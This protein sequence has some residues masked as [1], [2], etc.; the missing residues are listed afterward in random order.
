M[1]GTVAE[2][3]S[4]FGA[5]SDDIGKNI[6]FLWST[7]DSQRGPKKADWQELRQYLF[8]TD[9]STTSNASLPWKNT[10]TIPKLCQ[11][12]DNLHSNY[13]S[14]LFPN[15]NWLKWEGAAEDDDS[16]DKQKA[17]TGYMSNKV[18]ESN[19][20][21]TVSE[22]VYDY[23]DYGNAFYD[24]TYENNNFIN[25]DGEFIQGYTG[26]VIQRVSP[27]DIVFNPI[28]P[29]FAKSPKI[30]RRLFTRG[31]VRKLAENNTDWA[32][33][34]DKSDE[35][36]RTVSGMHHLADVDK[37]IG[38]QMDGFGGMKDYYG[39]EVI[40][41]LFFEGDYYDTTTNKLVTDMEIVVVDRSITV[42]QGKI[43]SW[44][45]KSHKG[46]VGWRKR[47]DNLYAMGPLDNLIGMQYRID[48]LQ[49]LKADAM[50]LIVHPPL[51]IKGDVDAFEWGPNAEIVIPGDG[52][53]SE[54]GKNLNGVIA[55]QNEINELMAL[56][57]EM[58]GAPKQAMGIRTPGEKTAF[59][60]Q[61]LDNAAGR[62]FQE[63]TVNFEINILEPSL[64]A[65][66]EEGR[67]KLDGVDIARVLDDDLGVESF[68][69]ISKADITA[70][71]KLRP[72]GARHF[73]QQAQLLQSI[74]IAMSGELGAK[75]TPHFSG[76]G[77]AELIA[78]SLQINNLNIV[79]PNVGVMEQ[80]E[81]QKLAMAAQE[82]T[83]VEQGTPA[84]GED[85]NDQ[86]ATVQPPQG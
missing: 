46:H 42:S 75:V 22:L 34:A 23:I 15:D 47:T 10:T 73:A 59:E 16:K 26:P 19:Y 36:R 18:R 79:R 77:L 43:K 54:L 84:P 58:A 2:L 86:Q 9:T 85:V 80:M 57:E 49:N 3:K 6:G 62:I 45:G 29:S 40:E 50:D 61:S 1:A 51:V 74:Q 35:I 64:N 71:G 39:S 8:A 25:D 32:L 55:A 81:T 63:K 24:V 31:E 65:M 28:A 12:R 52:D 70:R 11:I 83:E 78:D 4:Q 48:H 13:I 69:S 56:M 82:N 37:A 27:L 7:W 68:L 21:D 17:I 76:I 41:V 5:I 44:L 30:V 60:V 33:A 14:S 67:R 38:L 66:L 20:R 72:I 53:V